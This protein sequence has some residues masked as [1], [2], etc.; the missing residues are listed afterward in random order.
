MDLHSEKIP[1]EF[2]AENREVKE[3]DVHGTDETMAPY[4]LKV[5]KCWRVRKVT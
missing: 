3:P 1:E 2:L 5:L 4:D